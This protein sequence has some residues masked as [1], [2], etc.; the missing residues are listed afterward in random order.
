MLQ[1]ECFVLHTRQVTD[2]ERKKNRPLT[3]LHFN[4]LSIKMFEDSIMYGRTLA[5]ENS[6]AQ[7]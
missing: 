7:R 6:V 2:K 1:Y 4:I 3:A 5:Y